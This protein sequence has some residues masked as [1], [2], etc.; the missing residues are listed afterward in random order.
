MFSIHYMFF[1]SGRSSIL[2]LDALERTKKTCSSCSGR[3]TFDVWQLVIQNVSVFCRLR[4]I[5]HACKHR[6]KQ[7]SV[8]PETNRFLHYLF[9]LQ[10]LQ[11]WNLLIDI[12]VTTVKQRLLLN[13]KLLHC[14]N[15]ILRLSL[16]SAIVLAPWGNLYGEKKY[17]SMLSTFKNVFC[18][19]V[20]CF[21]A[22][23][24]KHVIITIFKDFLETYIILSIA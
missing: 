21:H 20:L 14:T 23:R 8:T 3:G 4:V 10:A 17:I 24:I 12:M 1:C 6:F 13:L 2:D 22:L 7:S 11:S 19:L 18:K 5:A 15:T 9:M 16:E